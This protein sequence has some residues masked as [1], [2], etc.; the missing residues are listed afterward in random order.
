MLGKQHY[1]LGNLH[2]A[3][4]Y[5]ER[6]HRGKAEGAQ[7]NLKELSSNLYKKKQERKKAGDGLHILDES[8]QQRDERPPYTRS[9]ELCK[10]LPSKIVK[11][12]LRS[13][14]NY[15]KVEPEQLDEENHAF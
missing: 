8:Q 7:S 1:Y 13:R 10:Q 11:I 6:S 3:Q 15:Y 5:I 14:E 9:L 4:Y 2:K 12:A